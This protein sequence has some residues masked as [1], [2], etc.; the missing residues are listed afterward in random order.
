MRFNLTLP[1]FG[2]SK[3][4]KPANKGGHSKDGGTVLNKD[5]KDEQTPE[6]KA[7]EIWQKSVNPN[8][9]DTS[10]YQRYTAGTGGRTTR[11]QQN[12]ISGATNSTT[13]KKRPTTGDPLGNTRKRR[14]VYQDSKGGVNRRSFLGS[15][16]RAL[17][18]LTG[19]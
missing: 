14:G 9:A 15:F 17:K 8:T 4:K 1:G 10:L 18:S 16:S 19:R 3:K 5:P 11:T 7:E 13:L 6:E 2:G 12:T